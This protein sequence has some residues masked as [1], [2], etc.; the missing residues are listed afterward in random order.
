MHDGMLYQKAHAPCKLREN[1]RNWNIKEHSSNY[2]GKSKNLMHF[3][4]NL[5]KAFA[6]IGDI[7]LSKK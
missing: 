7:V 6:K 4:P 3:L 2:L 1:T 5:W